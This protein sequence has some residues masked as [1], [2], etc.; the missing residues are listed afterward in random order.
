MSVSA[1][2]Q[3]QMPN[4]IMEGDDAKLPEVSEALEAS[5][6]AEMLKSAGFGET[7]DAFG[8][9]EGEDQFASFLVQE[10]AKKIVAAGGIGLAEQIFNTLKERTHGDS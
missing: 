6:L 3:S 1:L 4:P 8:G 10:Q 9:G 2:S 5:F 7:P